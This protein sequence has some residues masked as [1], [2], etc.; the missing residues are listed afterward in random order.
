MGS[1]IEVPWRWG[2]QSGPVP[3]GWGKLFAVPGG[4]HRL[5]LRDVV[6]AKGDDGRVRIPRPLHLEE[7]TRACAVDLEKDLGK[8]GHAWYGQVQVSSDEVV[9]FSRGRVIVGS[10]KNH[11]PP[12]GK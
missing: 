3:M 9:W 10:K 11:R 1:A 6:V 2:P 7:Q 5:V 4:S 8:S 12:L